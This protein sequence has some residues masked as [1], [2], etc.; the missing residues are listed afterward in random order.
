[1]SP[2]KRPDIVGLEWDERNEAHVEEHIPPWL[3][4]EMIEGGDWDA[5]ANDDRHPPEHRKLVGR[6]PA[7][8]WVTAILRGPSADNPGFWRPITAWYSA[9]GEKNRYRA[10]RRREGKHR[11]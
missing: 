2:P 5:F 8:I 4:E 10:E 7:G 9:E 6:T 11:G 1:M 3:V